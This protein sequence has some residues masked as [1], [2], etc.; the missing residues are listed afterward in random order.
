MFGLFEPLMQFP[1]GYTV[2]VPGQEF[3]RCGKIKPADFIVFIG[4][5]YLASSDIHR[6]RKLRHNQKIIRPV[7]GVGE[8]RARYSGLRLQLQQWAPGIDLDTGFFQQFTF[9]GFERSFIILGAAGNKMP[10]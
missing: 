3:V 2:A 8:G 1:E 4:E 9:C 7:V 5:C 10:H 6:K